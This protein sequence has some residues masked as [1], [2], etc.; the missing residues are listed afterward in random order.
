MTHSDESTY[1]HTVHHHPRVA[2]LAIMRIK[3]C[4]VANVHL[5]A[6]AL[7]DLVSR[8]LEDAGLTHKDSIEQREKHKERKETEEDVLVLQLASRAGVC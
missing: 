2:P 1:L 4:L 7:V 3:K 6:K 8:L 5:L